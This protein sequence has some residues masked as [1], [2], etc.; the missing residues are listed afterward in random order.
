VN[1][2]PPDELHAA[3]LRVADIVETQMQQCG[4]YSDGAPI[5]AQVLIYAMLP[6]D[7]AT[8]FDWDQ[9][10]TAFRRTRRDG[11]RA[12]VKALHDDLRDVLAA[13]L[14]GEIGLAGGGTRY[15][16]AQIRQLANIPA[17]TPAP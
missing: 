4:I 16:P 13:E 11:T 2:T 12:A 14:G 15:T 9:W 1:S 6:L 17:A 5:S 8:A 10:A 7:P 3:V